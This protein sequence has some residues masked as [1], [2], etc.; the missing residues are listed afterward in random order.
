MPRRLFGSVLAV[1]LLSCSDSLDTSLDNK[2]C[3]I[4][5][6]CLPGY[7]CSDAGFCERASDAGTLPDSGQDDDGD[8][9][10]TTTSVVDASSAVPVLDASS[11][12]PAIQDAEPPV[13][14]APQSEPDAGATTHPRRESPQAVPTQADPPDSPPAQ[15]PQSVNPPAPRTPKPP[16]PP[17]M[18]SPKGR[19]RGGP[20]PS[21]RAPDAPDAMNECGPGRTRCGSTCVDLERESS[22][23]GACDHACTLDETCSAGQCVLQKPAA[24]PE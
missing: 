24:G 8:D 21:P 3:E 16:P 17:R 23:C 5:H 15:D 14:T 11:E 2:R 10:G 22:S 13:T 6:R 18:D 1:L 12:V 20:P 9:S 7:E 19:P 4:T